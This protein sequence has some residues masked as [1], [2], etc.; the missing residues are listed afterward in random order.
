MKVLKRLFLAAAVII[1]LIT[2]RYLLYDYVAS[3]REGYVLKELSQIV[4]RNTPVANT[5]QETRQESGV[6]VQLTRQELVAPARQGSRHDQA[7]AEENRDDETDAFVSET[8]PND[9]SGLVALV[10]DYLREAV[11][12]SDQSVDM[13]RLVIMPAP[14]VGENPADQ[15][16]DIEQEQKPVFS[17]KAQGFDRAR[18]ASPEQ[19]LDDYIEQIVEQYITNDDTWVV[20]GEIIDLNVHVEPAAILPQYE[21][22]Y[23]QNPDMVGWIKIEDTQVNY[24]VMQSPEDPWFYLR[25]D[26]DREYAYSGLPFLDSCCDIS[27]PIS[28]LLIFGHNMKNGTMFGQLPKYKDK[29]FWEQHQLIQFDLLN[30]TRTY[31]I[32]GIFQSKQYKDDEEGFRY[33]E[34]TDLTEMDRFIE[35][36]EQVQ[37]ASIIDTGITANWGDQLLTL[38]T[39]SYYVDDGTFVVVAKRQL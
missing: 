5:A 14:A 32:I 36:I 17:V 34:Y 18:W 10:Q 2:G 4:E 8:E 11:T 30:E 6:S 33:Y 37:R 9:T 1:F 15:V 35:Y 39:C 38:S 29:A 28:N 31:E 13:V 23:S 24:P 26:F 19:A 3:A 7:K 21:A 27:T 12:C 25:H 20:Q 16:E 22:L